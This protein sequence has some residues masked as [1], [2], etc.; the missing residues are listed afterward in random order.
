MAFRP[1]LWPTL[2]TIPT[3]IVLLGLGTWQLERLH[4]KE[5]LIAERTARTTALPISVPAPS[6]PLPAEV[7]DE[8]DYFHA[9]VVGQFLHDRE[10]YL[11]ARTMEGSVGFQIVTPLLRSD[12]S[13]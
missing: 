3:L 11:A 5:A 10:M 4:W 1:T 6:V 9:T 13:I 2:F 7:L 8:L 12:G